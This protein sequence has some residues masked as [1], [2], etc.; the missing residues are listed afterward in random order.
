MENLEKEKGAATSVTPRKEVRI[1]L[2]LYGGV[3]LAVYIGG[4]VTEFLRVVRASKKLESNAYDTVLDHINSE[5]TVDIIS[6]TSAGGLN[7]VLLAKALCNGLSMRSFRNVRTL[8]L[9]EADFSLLVNSGRP[10]ATSVLDEA[11]FEEDCNQVLRQ[12]DAEAVQATKNKVP[13]KPA[14]SALDLFVISTNLNGRILPEKELMEDYF[15]NPIE[16][17]DYRKV[18]HLKFRTKG[19]NPSDQELGYDRNDLAPEENERLL[20]ICRATSAYPVALSPVRLEKGDEVAASLLEP[21]D[22]EVAY[23]SDGGALD[24]KPFSETIN[25][26]FGRSA[27]GEV[28][29]ILFYVEPDPETFMRRS[30]QK[31]AE[32]TFWD[33]LVKMGFGIRS[34]ESIAGDIAS[35]KDRNERI[36]RFKEIL[37]G[38]EGLVRQTK[39]PHTGKSL[40]ELDEE[41]FRRYLE[42]QVLFRGYQNLKIS[43]LRSR[44]SDQL[45][46]RSR[47]L[48]ELDTATSLK[49]KQAFDE[50]LD[51]L[52]EGR[53]HKSFLEAFDAPYRARRSFRL[54]E[55]MELAYQFKYLSETDHTTIA[56]LL[57]R[58][59]ANL[60]RANFIE[61]R[62]WESG[63]TKP[64]G[65]FR[66]PL[67]A[68]KEDI[69]T[70]DKESLKSK[71]GALLESMLQP[72][73]TDFKGL[74]REYEELSEKGK[75]LAREADG[76]IENLVRRSKK[77][78]EFFPSLS[79]TFVQ[80]EFR[81]MFI[82]P[83]ESL[84]NLGERDPIDIVRISPKDA[85]Y[86]KSDPK[87]KLSGDTLGHFGG[88]LKRE[89]RKNDILWGRLD[90]AELIVRTLCRDDPC[91]RAKQNDMI[92][93]IHREILKEEP[94]KG[95]TSLEDYRRYLDEEYKVGEEDL[96]DVGFDK[97][98]TLGLDVM[99]TLRNM[100]RHV[101]HSENKLHRALL[102]VNGL[103]L[104][105]LNYVLI[106]ATV[107]VK[108]L[109]AEDPFVRVMFRTIIFAVGTWGTITLVLGAVG[110]ILSIDW[111]TL[112]WLLLGIAAAAMAIFLLYVYLIMKFVKRTKRRRP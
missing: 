85:A 41:E 88:F 106:P 38:V 62:T 100:A 42:E 82:Y 72:A 43:Q 30:G 91:A 23:L 22:G 75:Q 73:G 69:K 34:Y 61:W 87:S 6:G 35:I 40:A 8:W 25:T 18:F 109:F 52:I 24:N 80:F 93:E 59:W 94:L 79:Q 76:F 56:K 58:L 63:G 21:G 97:M 14:V 101:Q 7:G 46:A 53:G 64:E 103:L 74:S 12:M 105:V 15:K 89:W 112:D 51:E 11:I 55:E 67:L 26:I 3:S 78:S 4:V 1:G 71:F 102:T 32:P 99:K 66:K 2:V 10:R 31:P 37:D 92:E 86:I 77:E 9:E 104:K 54:I 108:A 50:A 110:K 49:V 84:A 19:Y 44:L 5:V 65:W 47:G 96:A 17:K 70:L 48:N 28:N 13:L 39:D 16:A 95:L 107:L 68:L 98:A 45:L 36:H 111:L 81:D 29:R 33:I 83:I 57:E 20:R 27:F 60:D 90:A